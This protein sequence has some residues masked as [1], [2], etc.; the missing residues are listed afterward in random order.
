[1]A[2]AAGVAIE[3]IAGTG[4]NG[5]VVMADVQTAIR[6]GVPSSVAS[7]AGDDTSGL[8][9]FFPPFEDVSVSQIKKVTASRLT[10]SK[11]TVPHFYLSV[12]VRMDKLAA[13]R[14]ELNAGL[15]KSSGG[16]ISV[17]DFVV[18][19]SA[20]ALRAADAILGRHERNDGYGHGSAEGYSRVYHHR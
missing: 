8:A 17:N 14:G 15:E 10:E 11:R 16:K 19:A 13:L 7:A 4:P 1:M 3:R 9:R 5:R 18:K 20:K 6:D 12:D 2:E